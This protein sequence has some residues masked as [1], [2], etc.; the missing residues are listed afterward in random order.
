M[1]AILINSLA[2]TVT[3]IELGKGIEAIYAA[4]TSADPDFSGTFDVVGLTERESMF[5]DDE[6]FLNDGRSVFLLNGHPL[7]GAGL[8]LG[9]DDEGESVSSDLTLVSVKRNI[10]W[11]DQVSSGDFTPTTE[12]VTD[13]SHIMGAGVPMII[14]GTPILR[15]K[16]SEE[17]L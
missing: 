16:T 10:Q 17:G 3:E 13:E 1:R 12:G 2:R 14:G 8:V 11:T 9:T 7:A 15:D 6:G 5:V 4:L